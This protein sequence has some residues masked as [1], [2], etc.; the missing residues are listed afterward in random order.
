MSLMCC[1]HTGLKRETVR[2]PVSI[3]VSFP[4]GSD[5][6]KAMKILDPDMEAIED[7]RTALLAI[8]CFHLDSVRER[9]RFILYFTS[10]CYS[11]LFST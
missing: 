3:T 5:M 8:D 11:N 7:G 1:F 10:T 4:I 6:A 9:I 2:F